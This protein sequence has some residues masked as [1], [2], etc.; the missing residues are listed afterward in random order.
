MCMEWGMKMADELGLEVVLSAG[1]HG[2]AL[3]E[4]NGFVYLQENRLGVTT[5]TPGVVPTFVTSLLRLLRLGMRKFRTLPVAHLFHSPVARS[6]HHEGSDNT[7]G[8]FQFRGF[9]H[10]PLEETNEVNWRADQDLEAQRVSQL[11]HTIQNGNSGD[12]RD[13]THGT[14][15][16]LAHQIWRE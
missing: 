8:G 10:S 3:Y 14:W 7:T 15:S 5:E 9:E 4:A 6:K 16:H 1:E 2:R 13:K 11:E 12:L